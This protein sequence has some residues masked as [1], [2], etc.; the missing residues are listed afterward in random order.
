MQHD[1][2]KGPKNMF[3]L[4]HDDN[5]WGTHLLSKT[6]NQLAAWCMQLMS[7]SYHNSH[8]YQSSVQNMTILSFLKIARNNGFIF[9][10]I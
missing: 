4:G 3:G 2:L 7:S 5:L 10:H 9:L 6:A 1:L 8:D